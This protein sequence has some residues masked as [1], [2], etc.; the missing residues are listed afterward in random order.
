MRDARHHGQAGRASLRTQGLVTCLRAS[1][2]GDQTKEVP[3][4]MLR[5]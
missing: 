1:D 4:G 2:F 5:V 3:L